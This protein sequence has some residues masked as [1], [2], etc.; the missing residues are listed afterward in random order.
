MLRNA[1]RSTLIKAKRYIEVGGRHN[2]KFFQIHFE[3]CDSFCLF[4]FFV[5]VVCNKY[6][7]KL[8]ISKPKFQAMKVLF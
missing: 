2:E 5:D 1:M 8:N 7:K 6:L 4:V 3:L